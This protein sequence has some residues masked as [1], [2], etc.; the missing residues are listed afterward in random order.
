MSNSLSFSVF[1]KITSALYVFLFPNPLSTPILSDV[2]MVETCQLLKAKRGLWI[3]FQGE[4]DINLKITNNFSL[5]GLIY[6]VQTI[7]KFS[8]AKPS[9]VLFCNST[10][11][12]WLNSYSRNK[13]LLIPL[14]WDISKNYAFDYH[15][16][17]SETSGYSAIVHS[18]HW[19]PH[20]SF[21]WLNYNYQIRNFSV[22]LCYALGH[23]FR[24]THHRI[25][26][27]SE[28]VTASWGFRSAWSTIRMWMKSM[29]QH[30]GPSVLTGPAAFCC[31]VLHSET[32]LGSTCVPYFF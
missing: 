31:C 17:C 20:W 24:F 3:L 28:T 23:C 13:C 30:S 2:L 9:G 11:P 26:G 8:V 16:S 5:Y 12:C 6:S 4:C 25:H 22:S 21:K 1:L 14:K 32:H 18:N 19:E 10:I 29:L 15:F 7:S 27:D